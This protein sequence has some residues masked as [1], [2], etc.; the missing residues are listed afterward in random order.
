MPSSLVIRI[1]VEILC[2]LLDIPSDVTIVAIR[3]MPSGSAYLDVETTFLSEEAEKEFRSA[4]AQDPP[5]EDT[6]VVYAR[7]V[8]VDEFPVLSCFSG[9][10]G[11]PS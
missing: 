6:A 2:H 7:Y 8:T 4:A 10:P 9:V 1:P 5:V 11:A 3:A